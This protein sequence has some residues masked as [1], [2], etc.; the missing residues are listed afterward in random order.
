MP[1]FKPKTTKKIKYNKKTSI[2]L[3]GKHKEFLNTFS[4][5]ETDI[6][7][8]LKLEKNI[9]KNQPRVFP[10]VLFIIF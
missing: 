10:F 8:E 1:T 9:L 5:E 7:P 6:I 3:D 4:K 2:T